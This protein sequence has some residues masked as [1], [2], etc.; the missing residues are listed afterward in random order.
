MSEKPRK[1]KG[2]P[3]QATHWLI[4]GDD[5]FAIQQ[6]TAELM[7]EN[8]PEDPMS[9]EVISGHVDSVDAALRQ[10][11]SAIEALQT[12]PFFGGKK[13]VHFKDVNFA[14][15]SVQGKSPVVQEILLK[16]LEIVTA[17]NPEQA[18][19]IVSCIGIDKRRSFFKKFSDAGKV[20]T[21]AKPELNR[22]RDLEAWMGEIESR[23]RERGLVAGPGVVERL[24]DAAGDDS[25]RLINEIEKLAL[26]CHPRTRIEEHDAR[27]LCQGTREMVVWDLC[28]TVTK[29]KALEALRLLK[30][31][32]F[33]NERPER[34]LIALENQVRL[35]ALGVFLLEQGKLKLVDRRGF[36]DCE[37][38]PGA[39]TFIS[40]NRKGERV[41]LF[42]LAKA[43]S[44][45]RHRP[46]ARWFRLIE[47]VHQAHLDMFG[48]G[49]DRE[50]LLESIVLKIASA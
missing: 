17:L 39:E 24:I 38:A 25:R 14:G 15:D 40:A 9:I 29:G 18:Q 7:T 21:Y 20:E 22:A 30:Q 33:Q 45:A 43:V 6:R 5:D 47:I 3:G 28:E 1:S 16:L 8:T 35:A 41:S 44:A 10:T 13:L 48:G 42:P 32:L 2:A 36:M 26:Y 37:L 4:T 49:S 12:L 50:Q 34:L 31:L 11:A 23:F 19:M 27:L 46:S